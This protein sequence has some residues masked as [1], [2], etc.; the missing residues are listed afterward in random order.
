MNLR[1]LVHKVTKFFPWHKERS[2]TF[3]SLVMGLFQSG[4]VQHHGLAQGFQNHASLK[5]NCERIRRFFAEQA[6]D[7]EIFAKALISMIS[8]STPKLHLILDRTNWKFGETDINY[9]VLAVR[10]GKITFP[11]M[12]EM[13]PHKGASDYALRCLILER[14]KN[15]FGLKCIQSFTADREFIGQDWIQYL[16]SHH[17]PFLFALRQVA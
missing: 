12:W 10:I 4:H 15:A 3:T 7:Y 8:Q 16:I 14:F 9:L 1:S 11:L 2:E 6:I 5:S 13:L 17:I